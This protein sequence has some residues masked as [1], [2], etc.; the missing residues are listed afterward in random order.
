MGVRTVCGAALILLVLASAAHS[1]AEPASER[2]LAEIANDY[3]AGER[4]QAVA[5]LALRSRE[6]V[7]SEVQRL[8]VVLSRAGAAGT[9]MRLAVI[10]LLAE[11]ALVDL[12]VAD[13]APVR[14]KLLGAAR[15]AGAAPAAARGSAFDRCFYLLAGLALQC[16]GHLESAHTL[17][18]EALKAARD[19]P[20][21]LTAKGAV[22]ETV[23]ALRT[24]DPSPDAPGRPL[25]RGGY[26]AESGGG[27]SLPA[28][29]LADAEEAYKR[30]LRFDPDLVAA[31]LRLG[32]VRLLQ[33]RTEEALADLERVAT[34]ARRPEHRHLAWLFGGR[35]REATGDLQGAAAAYREA[36]RHAPRAQAGLLA[37]GR[38]LDRLGD[39]AGAQEALDEASS[40]GRPDDPW[41]DYL[42]GQP[43]RLGELLAELRRLVQ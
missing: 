37:L 31:R 17:L 26:M 22:V 11:S 27:G 24:Y 38:A 19:D 12:E 30:A 20:E 39:T 15:L 13:F 33:G 41:V 18:L 36:V 29:R 4:Q 32:R 10:A 1:S 43:E 6:S 25:R 21:I 34:E 40:A 8:A 5:E 35:A 14:F 9:A 3:R 42:S 2:P 7:E 16:G 28:A 23:A